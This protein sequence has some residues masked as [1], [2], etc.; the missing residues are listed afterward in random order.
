MCFRSKQRPACTNSY[1]VFRIKLILC[2][3]E[4]EKQ[5]CA[6]TKRP[7]WKQ[8]WNP[9][10]SNCVRFLTPNN[11][12]RKLNVIKTS[13]A[14]WA[15]SYFTKKMHPTES[16]WVLVERGNGENQSPSAGRDAAR[17]QECILRRIQIYSDKSLTMG[18]K[19][20]NSLSLSLLFVIFVPFYAPKKKR[21][22]LQNR[23]HFFPP[24]NHEEA[25]MI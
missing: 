13:N 6:I 19:I 2:Y 14:L 11:E 1:Q 5:F 24:S 22:T 20:V 9:Q 18:N 8:Y 15:G 25:F 12:R 7:N 23:R 4:K 3:S 21:R 17:R 16:L 10:H